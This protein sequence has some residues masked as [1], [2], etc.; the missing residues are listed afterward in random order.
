[1]YQKQC[2]PDQAQPQKQ[3]YT[4]HSTLPR[5]HLI[6]LNSGIMTLCIT[7][8]YAQVLN[9]RWQSE[10]QA[11]CSSDSLER[12][13]VTS[14]W[15]IRPPSTIMSITPAHRLRLSWPTTVL[16]HG[17]GTWTVAALTLWW[18]TQPTDVPFCFI[19]PGAMAPPEYEELNRST[20]TRSTTGRS[21]GRHCRHR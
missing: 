18:S 10:K 14:C 16:I 3:N 12:E 7:L 9:S 2:R 19:R 20:V 11:S 13:D 5:S 6:L 4:C 1:M 15:A 17:R 8:L 21:V